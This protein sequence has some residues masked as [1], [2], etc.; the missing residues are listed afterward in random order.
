MVYGAQRFVDFQHFLTTVLL[1]EAIRRQVQTV[2][3]LFAARGDARQPATPPTHT[4]LMKQAQLRRRLRRTWLAP[5][6]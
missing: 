4:P 6:L 2:V 1:P 3:W 5:A